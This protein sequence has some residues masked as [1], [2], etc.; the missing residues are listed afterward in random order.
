M[1]EQ[2]YDCSPGLILWSG[3]SA[4]PRK[5]HYT[6]HSISIQSPKEKNRYF[7]RTAI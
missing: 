5:R 2:S 7:S 6:D 4:I 1:G 3:C